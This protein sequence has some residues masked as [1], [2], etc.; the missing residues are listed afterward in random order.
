M[1]MRRK[2]REVRE[3]AEILEII[4]KCK[5]CRIAMRDPDELYIVPMNFGHSF[6]DGVLT[7]YFHSANKGR[8]LDMLR[9]DDR[10]CFE[11]DGEHRLLEAGEACEYGYAWE[12]VIGTG[13]A[14]FI[15]GAAE[16]T[17]ALNALML[18]QTGR[19]FSINENA[20]SSVTVFKIT[21]DKLSAKRHL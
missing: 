7:L 18:Q 17:D 11:M 21:A 8:K 15:T 16:K 1:E 9:A 14:E 20:L 5:V 3:M 2:D 4:S 13:R 10:V 19:N 6:N 12:S